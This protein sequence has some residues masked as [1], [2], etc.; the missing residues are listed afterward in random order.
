MSVWFRHI[1]CTLVLILATCAAKAQENIGIDVLLDRYQRSCEECLNLRDRVE[2]GEKI[3]TEEAENMV[4]KFINLNRLLNDMAPE[5]NDTQ[6][7]RFKAIGNWFRTGNKPLA[8]NQRPLSKVTAALPSANAVTYS[9]SF[10]LPLPAQAAPLSAAGAEIRI[11]ILPSISFFPRTYGAMAGVQYGRWGGYARFSG[12]FNA[13]TPS[14]SCS[15]EG[16]LDNGSTVWPNGESTEKAL[17][18][19]AGPLYGLNS[20]L[21]IYAGLGYGK[22]QVLWQDIDGN[23]A[24]V[25]QGLRGF[26]AEAGALASWKNFTF[27]AGVSTISFRSLT[28]TLSL[29][30]NF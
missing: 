21:D 15:D 29:G 14:Y 9:E 30:I 17:Q 5:L 20:W 11:Y 8:L 10:I 3:P 25:G 22:Y 2:G 6:M 4:Q 13:A 7:T 26:C 19:T 28:P 12:R 23:W 24:S 18:I 1:F 27:G 16:I